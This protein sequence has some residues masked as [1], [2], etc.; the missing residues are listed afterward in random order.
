MGDMWRVDDEATVGASVDVV[1]SVCNEAPEVLA[2]TVRGCLAAS[3]VGKVIVVDDGSDQPVSLDLPASERRVSVCRLERNSGISAAR[4]EGIVRTASRYVACVNTEIVLEP[5][6]LDATSHVLDTTPACGAVFTKTTL[7]AATWLTGWRTAYHEIPTPPEDGPA[8]FAPGHAVL[9]RRAALDAIGGYD[10]RFRRC[11]EDR[12]VCRRLAKAGWS[13]IYAARSSC[14]SH[15]IDSVGLLGRKTALRA[16][17]CGD[18]R[19]TLLAGCAVILRFGCLRVLSSLW[20][21][22][23]AA[24]AV[25]PL[26]TSVT[27]WETVKMALAPQNGVRR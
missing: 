24:L 26:I 7:P 10:P 5:D 2:I 8:K 18:E 1:I 25:E 21:R 4:N 22:R 17:R 19:V 27:L 20:H 11:R 23:W 9:F 6:W 16:L 14:T 15:Q 12:D 3:R 13:T